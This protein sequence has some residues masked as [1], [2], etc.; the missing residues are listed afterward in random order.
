MSQV[1]FQHKSSMA[2][3]VFL[4]YFVGSLETTRE[5]CCC[6][7]GLTYWAMFSMCH[8]NS[9]TS[10]HAL[11]QS[12]SLSHIP[13]SA[14][15]SLADLWQR[16]PFTALDLLLH[17]YCFYCFDFFVCVYICFNLPCTFCGWVFILVL[18]IYRVLSLYCGLVFWELPGTF[19]V[20]IVAS[21]NL[22]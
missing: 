11:S 10:C 19:P 8:C 22:S 5:Q 9:S 6:P 15:P 13:A 18:Y 20:L 2:K 12:S 16:M 3:W 7:L 17:H 21:S 1:V 4:I 14:P